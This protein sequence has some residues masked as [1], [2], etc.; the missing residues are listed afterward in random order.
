MASAANQGKEH[1]SGGCAF[2]ATRF[3]LPAVG[4]TPVSRRVGRRLSMAGASLAWGAAGAEL[5]RP[6]VAEAA[7]TIGTSLDQV[8]AVNTVEAYGAYG[9]AV[10][11]WAA[12][13]R[14][15]INEPGSHGTVL[16]PPATYKVTH[17]PP[18]PSDHNQHERT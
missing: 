7:G 14:A 10:T 5:S 4:T 13:I 8:G 9:D 6:V 17:E 18:A 12:D 11:N 15:A 2:V 1:D 16:L 3:A